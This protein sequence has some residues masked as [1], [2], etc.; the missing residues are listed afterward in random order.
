M[1][2][3]VRF[4]FYFSFFVFNPLSAQPSP[5]IEMLLR[6]L[7]MAT[8]MTSVYYVDS[9]NNEK[10]IEDAINGML[11]KL[12]PH[13]QYSNA[14]DTKRMNESLEGSFEG[15]GVQ[16]NI[17][18]DTLIVI[19]PVSKGPSEKVGILAG[20][21][22]ISV[23]DTAIAG[24][25]MSREE[26]MS[27]LRGPKGTKVK[28]GIVRRGVKDVSFFTVKRD[29]IPVTT[30][31]AAFMV[32]PEIGLI[33]FSSFGQ[34][35]HTEVMDALGKLKAQGMQKL[36]IDLQGNGGGLLNVAA[37]I[38][39][40]FIPRGDTIVYTRGRNVPNQVFVSSGNKGF[41]EGR[42]AVLI[43]EYSASAA[44]ILTGAIQDQD[45]GI[46]VGRR[47]FGKGLV[48]RPI[49][50]PDG[51]MIRLTVSRYYTPSGRCIQKPYTK[52]DKDSYSKDVIN[53][54]NSGEL[55]SADSIHFPD[56]LKYTTCKQKRI[57]YGGGGIM[58]DYFVPLD[59]TKYT[60]FY[61]ELSAKGIIINASLHNLDK[62]RKQLSKQ[63][64]DFNTF[65]AQ[66]IVPDDLVEFIF[67]EGEKQ[68][69]KPKDDAERQE[70][71]PELKR[72]LK[73]LTARD[74]WDMSEYFAIIY[75]DDA[76]VKKAVEL[77]E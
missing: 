76:M 38:A 33:R 64:K 34:T 22:I 42:V 11:S 72:I 1:K 65:K 52:G 59:T 30:L 8:I 20:D 5:D 44:E 71:I 7:N 41:Q 54:Y 67:R 37:D 18:E 32:T 40:E 57:V 15:I 13:S 61:R 4:L 3:I 17:L 36:I 21:R 23:N 45:R 24:V 66:Y 19:Q 6:K 63:W 75:D 56:S 74:L 62:N 68:D 48:Q 2:R 25:N 70:T 27:R 49:E 26:I 29:K 31:D 69:I 14:K 35:T 55:T 9:V 39:S 73:A 51:S 16:F 50:L 28:L 10:L 47:S 58:P 43:D 60:R 53:R 77:L 12:D 46:V